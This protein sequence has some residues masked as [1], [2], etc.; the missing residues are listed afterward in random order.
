MGARHQDLALKYDIRAV[1]RSGLDLL[2]NGLARE[3]GRNLA[4]IEL[5]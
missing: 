4:R 3:K 2:I 5:M 1:Y